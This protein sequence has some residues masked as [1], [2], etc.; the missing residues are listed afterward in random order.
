M[1]FHQ[2]HQPIIITISIRI[3]IEINL[4]EQNALHNR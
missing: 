4:E 1:V 2:I 3:R